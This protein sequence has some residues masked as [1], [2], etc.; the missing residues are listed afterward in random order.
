MIAETQILM[1]YLPPSLG[2]LLVIIAAGLMGIFR[3][4]ALNKKSFD[5]TIDSLQRQLEVVKS[6]NEMLRKKLQDLTDEASG[7]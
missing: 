5:D 3:S 6:E 2:I 4:V 7:K 1:K